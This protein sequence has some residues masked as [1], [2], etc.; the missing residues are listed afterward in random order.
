MDAIM[1]ELD[2]MGEGEELDK[3]SSNFELNQGPKIQELSEEEA[4]AA[5]MASSSSVVALNSVQARN[6]R[7]GAS[8][9]D[10]KLTHQSRMLMLNNSASVL[11][12]VNVNLSAVEVR[13]TRVCLYHHLYNI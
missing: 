12:G 8:S 7:S 4:Q 3:S 2:E 10:G 5:L 13:L 11:H 6:G 9:I 1:Q